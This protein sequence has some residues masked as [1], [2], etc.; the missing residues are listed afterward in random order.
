MTHKNNRGGKDLNIKHSKTV[1][2]VI[3]GGC[4]MGGIFLSLTA[5]AT[6]SIVTAKNSPAQAD[7]CNKESKWG[8]T[9][10]D[11]GFREHK[12]TRKHAECLSEVRSKYD[13]CMDP[14]AK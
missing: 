3:F 9:A 6:D 14:G 10:C 11:R 7:I 5:G 4:L 2:V 12:D 13:T 8:V 1:G